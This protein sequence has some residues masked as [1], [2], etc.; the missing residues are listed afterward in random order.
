MR[1]Y[2]YL[3]VWL[4]CFHW[5]LSLT[6]KF[7]CFLNNP[8]L[9][10]TPFLVLLAE[11]KGD[12]DKQQ[13]HHRWTIINRLARYHEHT[14]IT[15]AD[16]R[17]WPQ[18]ICIFHIHIRD[19]WSK[20]IKHDIPQFLKR[21]LHLKHKLSHVWYWSRDLEALQDR[22][23]PEEGA[24][25]L[26]RSNNLAPCGRNHA[27]SPGKGPWT[28]TYM[29]L[30]NML[31]W[32][33]AESQSLKHCCPISPLST[34][35]YMLVPKGFFFQISP[36]LRFWTKTTTPSSWNVW[37]WA[38]QNAIFKRNAILFFVIEDK[39]QFVKTRIIVSNSR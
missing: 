15:R 11:Q 14:V 34:K 39:R 22:C 9:N 2:V 12:F 27:H 24:S 3:S 25:D 26:Y 38:Q 8:I 16:K 37:F 17:V 20:H 31:E 33:G 18:Y 36:F 6:F 21:C 32:V 30:T 35:A 19:K 23:R 13:S 7:L 1:P 4:N 28:D 29:W 10:A 5:C